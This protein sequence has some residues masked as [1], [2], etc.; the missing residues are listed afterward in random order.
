MTQ[1]V[2]DGKHLYSDRKIYAGY[3]GMGLSRK[4]NS[5][6]HNGKILHYA[7]AGELADCVIGGQ[8]VESNFDPAVCTRAINR[9]G[10][11]NLQSNFL[12]VVVE[13]DAD[14]ALFN[15][16]RVYLVNYAGD[17]C[18]MQQGE[19]LVVGAM[20]QTV[21]DVHRAVQYFCPQDTVDTTSIIRVAVK[22]SHQTQDDYVIDRVN[23]MSGVYE[24]V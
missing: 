10:H 12:G 6:V 4:L 21:R 20:E 14:P 15:Q 2:Y 8:V 13:V 24:E 7:F 22:N 17:K 5:V 18:E 23:L 9:L 19:F 16:H 3:Q 11:D 1:I